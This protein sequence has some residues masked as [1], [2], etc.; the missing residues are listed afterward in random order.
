M[1]GR[2]LSGADHDTAMRLT[3]ET[4][5]YGHYEQVAALVYTDCIDRRAGDISNLQNFC[6]H[7]VARVKSDIWTGHP[8]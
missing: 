1:K 6:L 7:V 8:L 5:R 2:Y 4:Q 3:R